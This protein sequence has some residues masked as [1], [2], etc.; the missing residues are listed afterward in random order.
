MASQNR[1]LTA[2]P[3]TASTA[4]KIN[5]ASSSGIVGPHRPETEMGRGTH[6][7]DM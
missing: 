5:K 3:I 4:H 2:N 7:A 1:D 6:H